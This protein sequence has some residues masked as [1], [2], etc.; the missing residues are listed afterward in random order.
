MSYGFLDIAVTPSVRAVQAAAGVDEF[1][2]HFAG[3][4]AF[5][6]FTG[7]EAAFIAERDS[8]YLATVSETGWP[9][10]QHRG[11]PRGFLKLLDE[12]TLGFADY[13]GNHQ[14][15]SVGNLAANDRA[16]LFLMD[17]PRR[18]RLKIYARIEVLALDTDPVL[19]EQLAVPGY[20]AHPERLFRLHLQSFDWNC[21]Q[22]I[23]PRF[24]EEEVAAAAR[25]LHERIARL[26][27]ENAGLRARLTAEEDR[28]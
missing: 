28:R 16:C 3:D 10:L 2:E 5:D 1:W 8:F 23:T 9:Y 4:R 22:H 21:P 18:T 11:G 13:R 6:R 24:T 7:N 15:I 20:R 12:R 19:A 25:A 17:Y 27:E 14:F 26:E